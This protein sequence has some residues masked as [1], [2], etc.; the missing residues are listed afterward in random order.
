MKKILII[1]LTI[2][3]VIAIAIFILYIF[4]FNISRA[5]SRDELRSVKESKEFGVFVAEYYSPEGFIL[6]PDNQKLYI[7]ES[8]VD[9]DWVYNNW[10]KPEINKGVYGL[11]VSFKE[12][13]NSSIANQNYS[14]Q[15]RNGKCLCNIGA[16][17]YR[18]PLHQFSIWSDIYKKEDTLKVYV[19]K[20]YS[21]SQTYD[22]LTSFILVKKK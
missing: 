21:E 2:L 17:D 14:Y 15:W 4:K 20:Y 22:T 11:Y 7:K 5:G 13:I 18:G 8:W 9:N 19:A 12:P 10:S 3:T 6:Y 1:M 16:I